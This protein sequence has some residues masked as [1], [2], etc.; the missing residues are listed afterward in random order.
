L[1]NP[2]GSPTERTRQIWGHTPMGRFGEA[3]EL[4]GAAI[5]LA[6]AKASGFVTGADL[7]VDGGFL[8]QTI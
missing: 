3:G 6:S 1:F 4:V 7:R 5:F 8:A 2:D